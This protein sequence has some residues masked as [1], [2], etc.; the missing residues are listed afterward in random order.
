MESEKQKTSPET[1]EAPEE[2]SILTFR[3]RLAIVFL[4]VFLGIVAF[5]CKKC[6][7]DSE[8][9]QEKIEQIIPSKPHPEKAG[10]SKSEKLTQETANQPPPELTKEDVIRDLIA[11]QYIKE[12]LLDEEEVEIL[13][14][15]KETI[16][17]LHTAIPKKVIS[18]LKKYD[19]QKSEILNKIFV[20][21]DDRMDES[22]L[23]EYLR[24]MKMDKNG[25]L[26]FSPDGE[27]HL[28]ALPPLNSGDSLFRL[29][30]TLVH[31][32][33]GHAFDNLDGQK[34]RFFEKPSDGIIEDPMKLCEFFSFRIQSEF[35]A[36]FRENHFRDWAIENEVPQFMSYQKEM[37]QRR[38]NDP[39]LDL[40]D[41]DLFE[42]YKRAQKTGDWTEFKETI[43]FI[44]L[45]GKRRIFT[46]YLLC[47]IAQ[48]NN[49][50]SLNKYRDGLQ[51]EKELD[52]FIK[53]FFG[54][55]ITP[56]EP[57]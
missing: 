42:I 47:K 29:A 55:V 49:A 51:G 3:Y 4:G 13:D 21:T 1:A 19:P 31:E 46:L 36:Y 40:P 20:L 12:I 9:T 17:P 54:D 24:K 28:I 7:C 15:T 39:E 56:E 8:D 44:N 11:M 32:I 16:T 30:Q 57:K 22:K 43:V 34:S 50:D 23:G 10:L 38:K 5:A 18:L 14:K 2:K 48:K 52:E 6:S 53:E 35:K 37:E 45:T 27:C 33:Y 41:F 26:S 25:Q